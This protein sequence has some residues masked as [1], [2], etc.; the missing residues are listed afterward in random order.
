MKSDDGNCHRYGGCVAM[1]ERR[2]TTAAKLKVVTILP[3]TKDGRH[4]APEQVWSDEDNARHAWEF[5]N[6]TKKSTL[7]NKYRPTTLKTRMNQQ[8]CFPSQ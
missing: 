5:V 7:R 2:A 8:C 1:E 4:C 6:Q 3:P